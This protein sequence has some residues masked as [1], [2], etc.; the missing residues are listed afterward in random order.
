MRNSHYSTAEILLRHCPS[1]SEL[2]SIQ[3]DRGETPAHV[4]CRNGDIQMAKML[5]SYDRDC[6]DDSVEAIRP[7]PVPVLLDTEEAL[8][9]GTFEDDVLRQYSIEE[10]NRVDRILEVGKTRISEQR[11]HLI[12]EQLTLE[13]EQNLCVICQSEKKSILLLPCRHLCL[14][15]NCSNK[16]VVGCPLCRKNIQDKI[17]VFS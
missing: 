14:C 12:E 6:T 17:S 9:L 3:N 4:A 5:S 13:V 7:P 8:I 15:Q 1:T 10:L 16:V 2:L 11:Q